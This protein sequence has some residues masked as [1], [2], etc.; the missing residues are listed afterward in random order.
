MMC[1]KPIDSLPLN[2]SVFGGSWLSVGLG[3]LIIIGLVFGITRY[4]SNS[5]ARAEAIARAATPATRAVSTPI[6]TPTPTPTVTDTPMPTA[7]F[8]VT[9]S[10][11]PLVHI[12][13]SGEYPELIAD[14]YGVNLEEFLKFN[15]IDDV[16]SLQV[17]QVLLIPT[18]AQP[19]SEAKNTEN[20]ET[21]QLIKYT[22]ESGDTLLGIALEYGTTI[23]AIQAANPDVNLD[24][25]FPSQEIMVPLAPPTPT[26]TPT[27][28]PTPTATPGPDY[29]APNLLSPGAGEVIDSSTL[30]FNWTSTS[31]LAP[32]EFYV[33]NLTWANG[34]HTEAWVKNS[35]WR[36]TTEQ[37]VSGGPI[38]WAVSI[39]RQTGAGPAGSPT[40]I[41][42]SPP[43]EQR[44]VEWRSK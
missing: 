37:R 22:V 26:P 16:S 28:P 12:V 42:L 29:L 13:Q 1:G 34:Q 38:L 40:G 43:G 18:N 23:E 9:P 7:T 10:P 3:V 11:T 35:S 6:T 44:T 39:M 4:Q 33:L 5:R 20:S 31:L 41:N 21:A 17:G 27:I 8:T 14:L 19:P 24:L 36:I 32:D 25:I 30:L 2:T 15:N